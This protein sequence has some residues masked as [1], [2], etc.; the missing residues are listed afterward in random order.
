MAH[1]GADE[2]NYFVQ[3]EHGKF[4]KILKNVEIKQEHDSMSSS[5]AVYSNLGS[6]M[7]GGYTQ[8]DGSNQ[9]HFVKMHHNNYTQPADNELTYTVI[10]AQG[11]SDRQTPTIKYETNSIIKYEAPHTQTVIKTERKAPKYIVNS[12][13]PTHY[14]SKAHTSAQSVQRKRKPEKTGKG[15]KHFSMKVCEKVKEKGTTTYNEVADELV[16]EEV[17]NQTN[18]STNC[19]QKNIRRRVYDALNVLMAM[20]IIAK[21]K[22][23]I[24][25]IGLPKN[26]VEQ[27][28]ALEQENAKR[29]ERIEAKQQQLRELLLQQVSF[30][31]LMERNKE[32][33]RQGIIPTPNSSIQL[34]FIIVNT[35]KSTKINCSV[36]ND[37]SE[38]IFKFNDKFEMHDDA[39]VLKQMGLL[40]GLDKGT[41]TYEDIEKAKTLVP[42]NFGKYI[43][44]YGR[45]EPID[46][47]SDDEMQYIEQEYITSDSIGL[48]RTREQSADLDD[49]DLIES[50]V[51]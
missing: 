30:K 13:Q 11:T 8:L 12:S 15:L 1:S 21:D 31:S 42:P 41:C 43:E 35:H 9:S 48:S 24:R 10:T 32:A 3:D 33:E 34:P 38:Y 16:A 18:E 39:E 40:L 51:D 28:S 14:K 4:L 6:S 46:C 19:D 49:D 25:W 5:S 17:Q 20:D 26:S 47:D 2:V 23:E 36:T 27:Y 44:A 22:K 50:D 45:G 37:K 29:R 7:G